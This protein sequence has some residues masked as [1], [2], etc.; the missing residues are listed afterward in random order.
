MRG[1]WTNASKKKEI[2][3]QI[4]IT[5]RIARF[6]AAGVLSNDALGDLDFK[7]TRL[8]LN[9]C[10]LFSNKTDPTRM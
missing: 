5:A 10:W 6:G 9:G 2:I 3:E 4:Q 7:L 1:T 8:V